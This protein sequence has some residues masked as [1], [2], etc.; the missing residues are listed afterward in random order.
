MKIFW[1][2]DFGDQSA[3]S[4]DRVSLT[5]T[6]MGPVLDA[7]WKS[8]S[9]ENN[10]EQSANED[11]LVFMRTLASNASPI[12]WAD[13]LASGLAA[14][15]LGTQAFKVSKY[16]TMPVVTFPYD[17]AILDLDI[18]P[19]E[20]D[21][22]LD[23]SRRTE[24]ANALAHLFYQE[25]S[26]LLSRDFM[27]YRPN[28]AG[29]ILALKLIQKGM[30]PERIFFLTGHGS[31]ISSTAKALLGSMIQEQCLAKTSSDI[32]KL[33]YKIRGNSYYMSRELVLNTIFLF[34]EKS[35]CATQQKFPFTEKIETFKLNDKNNINNLLDEIET[36]FSSYFPGNHDEIMR[37]RIGVDLIVKYFDALGPRNENG[38]ECK[39]NFL[40]TTYG[41]YTDDPTKK[42]YEYPA[43]HAARFLKNIRNVHAHSSYFH[44]VGAL[45]FCI[46]YILFLNF[47][48]AFYGLSE[49][50]FLPFV[51]NFLSEHFPEN[52]SSSIQW[53]NNE[54]IQSIS[55]EY[56]HF[57]QSDCPFFRTMVNFPLN[58]QVTPWE[59]V[60][61]NFWSQIS[62]SYFEDYEKA[63]FDRDA[64]YYL[65][66]QSISGMLADVLAEKIS[67]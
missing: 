59:I 28:C 1:V 27:D 33:R 26:E 13:S 10:W 54:F 22:I 2:E 43:R 51:E 36:L 3:R 60:R 50:D 17:V 55:D 42:V 62:F 40:F 39:V 52:T 24:D 4:S 38:K 37:Y 7:S 32:D 66:N 29:V 45:E 44:N 6:Y 48:R 9:G 18:P 16:E 58:L 53:S 35:M 15:E 64:L 20:N 23:E 21:G 34:R 11:A 31:A 49:N 65:K 63:S 67:R 47:I 30:P 46:I 56:R 61:V 14:L 25:S 57:R 41:Q 8:G 5:R 12:V 19:G